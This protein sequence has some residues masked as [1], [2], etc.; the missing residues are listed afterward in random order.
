MYHP[1][2]PPP[3]TQKNEHDSLFHSPSYYTTS[4]PS[5]IDTHTFARHWPVTYP[6]LSMTHAAKESDYLIAS[7]KYFGCFFVLHTFL[8]NVKIYPKYL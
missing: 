6:P 1:H 4:H 7:K 5:V 2:P 3:P 8:N